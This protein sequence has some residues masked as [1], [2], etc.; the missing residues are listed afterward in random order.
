M[1][2]FLAVFKKEIKAYVDHPLAYIL[3]IVFLV[4]NHFLFFRAASVEQVMS[5]RSMFG[6]LP[7]ML[8]FF[9]PALTMRSWAEERKEQTLSLL[10]SYP[11]PVW[12]V[13]AGKFVAAWAFITAILLVTVSIPASL[14]AAGD[15]DT[16]VIAAQYLGAILLSGAMVAV[17]QWASTL[18][19]NQVVAFVIAIGTLVT[20]YLI[21]LDAVLLSLPY[22]LNVIGQQLGML[23]HVQSLSRGLI[24]GRDV[25][26]FLSVMA[27]FGALSVAW[28][29]KQKTAP[30]DPLWRRLQ[31][32]VAVIIAI[33]V[34]VNLFGQSFTVRF[35]ATAQN[36]YSLSAATKRILADLDDTVRFTFYRSKKLPTQM[37]LVSR[38][39]Q[40]LLRDYQKFGG[41]HAELNVKYPDQ[42]EE[43]AMEAR[44]QGVPAIRFNVLSQDEF[45]V[46][47]GY[48]GIVVEFL[49]KQEVIPFVQSTDD[50]E[51]RLSRAI[52]ALRSTAKPKVGYV[53]DFGGKMLEEVAAFAEQLRQNY[54]IEDV[55]LSASEEGQ[56]VDQIDESIDVL[57]IAAPTQAYSEAAIAEVKNFVS[58]GGKIFWMLPG[59]TVDTSR[60]SA[61]GVKTGLEDI[62]AGAGIEVRQDL[63]AD[64]RSHETVNFSAGLFTYFYPYPYWVRA[65]TGRHVLAGNIQQVMLPWPSS[66]M[67]D[68][69][70]PGDAYPL[71]ETTPQGVRFTSNFQLSPDRLPDFTSLETASYTLAAA[72]ENIPAAEGQPA[73][74]WVIVANSEFLGD[75]MLAQFPQNGSLA[76]NAIDWLS[77]NDAL[78]AIRSKQSQPAAMIWPSK[79]AQT[80]AKWGNTVG[81]PIVV[82]LVGAVWLYR[83]RKY[84]NSTN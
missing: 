73:G 49:D 19:K 68:E 45:T 72:V 65:N 9:V 77:Q 79:S 37:E 16:G 59:V 44:E 48:I 8:L 67:L 17:G 38:D 36:I 18:S 40:D 54:T 56:A 26:Y 39:I 61:A 69:S 76:L 32:T 4:I 74:R 82:G 70:A 42:D 53:S 50:L 5:L 13:V 11:A 41:R 81:A 83:R 66:V 35:D 75:S 29:F 7:W 46:Q 24:D 22:P 71:V 3:A 14:S 55:R 57:I 43:A 63:V 78:V 34:V 25:L 6:L 2:A 30:R 64:I 60:L 84:I 47:E 1:K 27:V 52:L 21:S 33:A 80:A 12:V 20:F 15:F 23:S 51:Y 28:V 58:R 62:L 31:S 10:L